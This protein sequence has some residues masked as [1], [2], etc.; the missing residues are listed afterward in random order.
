MRPAGRLSVGWEKG[1]GRGVLSALWTSASVRWCGC[2]NL[3]QL[4]RSL[5]LNL[6]QWAL[7]GLFY[8]RE[9]GGLTGWEWEWGGAGGLSP[10]LQSYC[11]R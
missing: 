8:V 5:A 10:A 6:A 4:T 1:L 9:C 2:Q 11:P 3:P 7:G